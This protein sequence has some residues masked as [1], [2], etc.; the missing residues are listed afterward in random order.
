[1]NEEDVSNDLQEVIDSLLKCTE[2]DN[3]CSECEQMSECLKFIRVSVATSLMF[4][5]RLLASDEIPIEELD[6]KV[7]EA[8]SYFT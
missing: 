2:S 7:K 3:I 1:M 8:T 6:K 5:K 4:I